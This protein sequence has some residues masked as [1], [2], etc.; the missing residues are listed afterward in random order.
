MIKLINGQD[1]TFIKE[2]KDLSLRLYT[3]IYNICESHSYTCYELRMIIA[4]MIIAE[5]NLKHLVKDEIEALEN[6]YKK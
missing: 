5:P 2:A 3:T 1:E 6:K 4:N